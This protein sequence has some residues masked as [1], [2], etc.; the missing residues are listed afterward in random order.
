MDDINSNKA[1]VAE[2][3]ASAA[4]DKR[5]TIGLYVSL[6][7]E[8]PSTS[9]VDDAKALILYWIKN[10]SIIIKINYSHPIYKST[11]NTNHIEKLELPLLSHTRTL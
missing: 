5:K 1:S 6:N 11:N 3:G 9:R 8:K 7:H 10:C 4:I 2:T